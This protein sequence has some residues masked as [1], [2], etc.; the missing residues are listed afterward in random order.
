MAYLLSILLST[1]F[2]TLAG[3]HVYWGLGGKWAFA[4]A[5]PTKEDGTSLAKVP[6]MMASFVVAVG[7][8]AFGIFYLINGKIIP[9]VLSSY[10]SAYGYWVIASIFFLRAVGDFKYIGMFKKIKKTSFAKKD[11]KIYTPLCIFISCLTFLL[12]YLD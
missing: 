7:L 11:T 10:L 2:F 8:F 5:F 1:V 4:D 3:I 12:I 9:V 6:G